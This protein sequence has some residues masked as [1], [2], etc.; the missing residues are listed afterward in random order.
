MEDFFYY[1]HA[2]GR[3]TIDNDK[4]SLWFLI[5]RWRNRSQSKYYLIGK[6]KREKLEKIEVQN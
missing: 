5:R 3:G 1:T 6:L 4:F 2:S